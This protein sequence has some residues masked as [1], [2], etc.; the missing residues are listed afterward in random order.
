LQLKIFF[1]AF[2]ETARC[3]SCGKVG[4]VRRS[5][6]KHIF[7]SAIKATRVANIYKCRECG[8]RGVLK[9][10]TVNKYTFI[11][12]V[13]YSILIISVAYIITNIL[14]SNFGA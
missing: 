5:R 10:Y 8:W 4:T 14:K 6:A 1:K 2:P 7:E 13:F 3:P 12:I 9:K 11:T